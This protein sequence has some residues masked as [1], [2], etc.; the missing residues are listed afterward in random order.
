MTL[1]Y[2]M[3][4][5]YVFP[6]CVNTIHINQI[7]NKFLLWDS[8]RWCSFTIIHGQLQS[9][10]WIFGNKLKDSKVKSQYDANHWNFVYGVKKCL[11]K[12]YLTT[13]KVAL[14]SATDQIRLEPKRTVP[15]QIFRNLSKNAHLVKEVKGR[16]RTVFTGLDMCEVC[17][18]AV[19]C[20]TLWT[21]VT[22]QVWTCVKYVPMQSIA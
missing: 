13:E 7:Q 1:G 3:S 9:Q 6:N 16:N 15:L 12:W 17:T 19:H 21:R 14:I 22:L 4:I 10:V 20:V 2:F 11:W 8:S 18:E 5:P